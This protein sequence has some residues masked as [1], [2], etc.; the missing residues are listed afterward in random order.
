MFQAK[1]F[2]FVAVIAVVIL[3]FAGNRPIPAQANIGIVTPTPTGT[4]ATESRNQNESASSDT[5]EEIK[6][7]IQSY[8]EIRYRALS[9]S[10]PDNFQLTGFGDLVSDQPDAKASLDTELGKLAVDI[11][12]ARLNHLR[13]VDYKYSLDFK[14]IAVD[15][16]SQIATVSVTEGNEVTYEISKEHDPKNPIVS[17]MS[18]LEHT[19]MLRQEQ[20]GWKITS[21][22]YNDYLWRILRETGKS[23]SDM[24]DAVKAS[25]P[26][27]SVQSANAQAQVQCPNLPSGPTHA[28]DRTDA[29]TYALDHADSTKF[30]P[31]YPDYTNSGGDCTN[32]VSQAIYEGG[33][34]SMAIPSPLPYPDVGGYGWYLLN[35]MQRVAD[36]DDVSGFYD[37]VTHP[38]SWDEGPEGCDVSI[39]NLMPGDVIQYW[40]GSTWNHSVIVVEIR[41]GIPYVASHTPDKADI[42]Y[43]DYD[44]LVVTQIFDTFISSR[45]RG[46]L[47]SKPRSVK[48]VM[49]QAPTRRHALFHPPITKSILV[50]VS[51]AAILQAVSDS[52]ISKS[53]KALRSSMPISLSL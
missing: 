9:A 34:A 2:S 22:Y 31:D 45:V 53:H 10:Q 19:I 41:D 24:L 33:N 18:G 49:M 48:A 40:N 14:N 21:D 50:R 12:H 7:V 26:E 4:P 38:Y 51:A 5:Q 13:Y 25:L 23:A 47:Q 46:I 17:R 16:S 8:F 44:S 29:V 20:G 6:S 28:Y 39:D 30:N 3:L 52:I 1:R 11:K 36:W 15:T 43:N 37:F 27:P 42:P 35:D 32:F